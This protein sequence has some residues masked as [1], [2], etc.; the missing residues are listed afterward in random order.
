MGPASDRLDFKARRHHPYRQKSCSAAE[1]QANRV[2]ARIRTLFAWAVGKDLIGTNPC[3][4]VK[5]PT[6]EKA[7]DRV[8]SET[9]IGAFWAAAGE[10][11]WPFGP[12][13]RCSSNSSAAR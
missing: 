9:E 7:R 4:G 5:P 13:F 2:L 10:L 6:K 11:D 1:V 8:L 12:L 3:D